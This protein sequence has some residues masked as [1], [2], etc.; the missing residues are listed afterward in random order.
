MAKALIRVRV[1]ENRDADLNAM[2]A[3]FIEA[4]KGETIEPLSVIT[5]ETPSQLFSVLS[6][7]RWQLIEQLQAIGASSIRAL[8]RA[9]GRDVK[10]VHEDVVLLIEWGLVEKAEDGRIIVPYSEIEADFVLKAS[11]A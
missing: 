1:A 11:A 8:A 5:F 2:G 9:L 3:R 10:R 7:K 6:P 4:W